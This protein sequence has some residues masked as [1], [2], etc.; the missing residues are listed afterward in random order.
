MRNHVLATVAAVGMTT[1]LV[2][3]AIPPMPVAKKIPVTDTYFGTTVVDPYRWMETTPQTPEFQAYLKANADRTRTILDSLPGRAKL[4]ERIAQL[5]ETSIQSS[6]VI[7]H[8]GT[9][10]YER[11]PQGANS[12]KLFVR[13]G[14]KG[15]EKLLVDPDTMT[16]PRQAIGYFL[17]SNDGTKVAVGLAAG[18]SENTNVHV[19]DVASGKMLADVVDRADFGLTSWSD[20]GKSFYYLK[21]QAIAAGEPPTAKYFNVKTFA[22]TVG[23]PAESDA[24]VFGIGVNPSVTATPT[25]FAAMLVT[26]ESP[27]IA[28]VLINGVDRFVTVYVA[29]K[30]ALSKPASIPWKLVVSPE[31]KITGAYLHGSTIY[32]RTAK[33]APRFKIIAF[34][35]GSGSVA[36][37]KDVIPASARVIDEVAPASDALYVASREDGLGRM[38]RMSY[39]D[40]KVT[41]I[42]LP[43]NGTIGGLQT[44][45]DRPGFIARLESWTTS[46]LWFA[47]DPAKGTVADTKLDAPA[48]VDYSAIVADEVK[49]PARDGTMIPLS[50]VHRKDTKRDGSNPTLL[51]AYGSYGISTPPGFVAGRL[52]FLERGGIYAFAHV[53]G[54]G[55]YGEEWHLAGKDANKVN[56]ANDFIDCAAYLEKERYTS[57]A[58]LGAR[59]GSAGGITMGMSIDTAPQL[60]A[61]VLDEVPVSDQLRIETT[62][63]GP[64]NI[65]EFGSV[66]SETGFK[67]LYATSAFHHVV[68]GTKYPAVMLTTGINDPRVD[69]WQAAK[70]AAALGAATGSAKPILLRIDYDGG[71]GGIGSSKAQSVATSADELAFLFWQ[72]GD[73]AFQPK[74]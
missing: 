57:P 8:H 35:I 5:A 11:T 54:G 3:A 1:T 64:A 23:A 45:F 15:T 26:P 20:D 12:A 2:S 46:P 63:N 28:G 73:P 51:Y 24:P 29:P 44:E 43:V 6:G 34:D 38:S 56:T 10:F 18:G 72:F 71:H 39:T 40:G 7:L 41:D 69:P 31:D 58:K 13:V 32:A 30:S 16:G 27:F 25:Q 50:I 49:V 74:I 36:T 55:E 19:V 70:M 52:A 61:A 22:H 21:R 4:A 14:A 59:G 53:R 9:Y 47:Y 33:N 42:P 67:N 65:P 66:K 60:F 17:P 48:S 68:P 37:A 62:A